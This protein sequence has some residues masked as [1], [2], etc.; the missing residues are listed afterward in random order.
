MSQTLGVIG[1]EASAGYVAKGVRDKGYDAFLK[2]AEKAAEILS[3]RDFPRR[4]RIAIASRLASGKGTEYDPEWL[5]LVDKKNPFSY[6]IP[7]A[8]QAKLKIRGLCAKVMTQRINI[9]EM[10]K[11]IREMI[12]ESDL[13]KNL[14][15]GRGDVNL[16]VF[17]MLGRGIAARQRY[18]EEDEAWEAFGKLREMT[19]EREISA[20]GLQ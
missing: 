1:D 11:E 18:G 17:C 6:N 13:L 5:S 19:C 9:A 2:D 4:R 14:G 16:S 3:D 12:G 8:D 7:A 20:P 10:E 15:A